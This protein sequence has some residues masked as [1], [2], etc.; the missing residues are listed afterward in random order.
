MAVEDELSEV[1]A[2]A[3]T[4][5]LVAIVGTMTS[6]CSGGSAKY[7]DEPPSGRCISDDG[8]AGACRLGGNGGGSMRPA[9][10]V[11]TFISSIGEGVETGSPFCRIVTPLEITGDDIETVDVDVDSELRF[12]RRM[13]GD[14]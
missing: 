13:F 8:V 3:S 4:S 10:G 12:E 1:I 11:E 14:G 9:D 2:V 6:C 5:M 7:C